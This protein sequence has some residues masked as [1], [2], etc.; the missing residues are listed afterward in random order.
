M[1]ADVE[2]LDIEERRV[3]VLCSPGRPGRKG[4]RHRVED[5]IEIALAGEACAEVGG[6]SERVCRKFRST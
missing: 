5:F 2:I 1:A 6:L 3:G 4:S